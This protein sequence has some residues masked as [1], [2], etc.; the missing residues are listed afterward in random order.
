MPRVNYQYETSPKKIKPEYERKKKKKKPTKKEIDKKIELE[1]LEKEKQRKMA[2][3]QE[4]RRQHKN[5]AL[6]ISIFLI[7][8]AISYR[9]SLINEKFNEIQTKK[10]ELS[11]IEKTNGQL[12]VGIEESIN[13]SN[14]E[15]EAKKK[16]GM[17]KLKNNQKV[18]VNLNNKDYTESGKNEIK[19]KEQE[20]NWFEKI[21]NS[22]FK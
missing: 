15:T 5:I 7:V 19:I 16:L 6:I 18:Y 17:Q 11:T 3:K 12:Q 13:L 8:L 2:L 21:I 14:V 9:N 4:K 10:A 1:K 20:Q 22:I